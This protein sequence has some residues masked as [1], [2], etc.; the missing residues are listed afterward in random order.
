ML[1]N[2]D[3]SFAFEK[4]YGGNGLRNAAI[5]DSGSVN[6]PAGYDETV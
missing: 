3:C 4:S 6:N 1:L 5:F 2:P